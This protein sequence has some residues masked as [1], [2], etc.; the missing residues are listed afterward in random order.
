MQELPPAFKNPFHQVNEELIDHFNSQTQPAFS[1]GWVSCLVESMS[2]WSNRWTCPGWMFV[3]RKPH[4]G[5]GFS[6]E[7]V[8][9][10]IEKQVLRSTPVL[11]NRQNQMGNCPI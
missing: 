7:E 8:K 11:T 10:L 6:T 4:D 2:V 5:L 9:A 1:P 3:P